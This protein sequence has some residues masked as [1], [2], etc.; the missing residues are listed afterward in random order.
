[1]GKHPFRIASLRTSWSIICLFRLDGVSLNLNCPTTLNSSFLNVCKL[2]KINEHQ[3]VIWKS[4]RI[5]VKIWVLVLKKITI[6]MYLGHP[7]KTK[8]KVHFQ[9]K[10]ILFLS[11]QRATSI[12][13]LLRIGFAPKIKYN[14][15]KQRGRY[16][17]CHRVEIIKE[18]VQLSLW[19]LCIRHLIWNYHKLKKKI[20]NCLMVSIVSVPA[21]LMPVI[22]WAVILIPNWLD[23]PLLNYNQP[24]VTLFYQHR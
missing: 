15:K 23:R 3:Q 18:I 4:W 1:M 17:K 5:F 12:M 9:M 8:I 10:Q 13:K 21:I 22:I 14:L 2:I 11:N 7:M 6:E 16:R 24:K 19:N 20:E